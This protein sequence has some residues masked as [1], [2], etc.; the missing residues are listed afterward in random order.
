M[1]TDV[2]PHQHDRAA[3]LDA[4]PDEQV[5]QVRQPNPFGWSFRS[6]YSRTEQNTR[7][8]SPGL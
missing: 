3:E 4:G 6:V 1:D 8:R 5:T 2:V 7:D